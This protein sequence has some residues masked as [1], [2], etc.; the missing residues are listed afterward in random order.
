MDIPSRRIIQAGILCAA[1]LLG[2]L[3][4]TAPPSGAANTAGSLDTTFGSGGV[5]TTD[6]HGDESVPA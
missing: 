6:I 5:L 4:A 3:S 1:L 2:G